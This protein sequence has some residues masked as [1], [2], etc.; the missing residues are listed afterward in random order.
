MQCSRCVFF[1]GTCVFVVVGGGDG[2]GGGG[3]GC[4]GTVLVLYRR[5]Q[6]HVFVVI[7]GVVVVGDVDGGGGGQWWA[8]PEDA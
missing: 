2:N 7:A 5:V 1:V 6:W 4:L 3:K 8:K